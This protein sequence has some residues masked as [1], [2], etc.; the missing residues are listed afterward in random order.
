VSRRRP[1]WSSLGIDP[2]G[3][4]REIKRAYAKK[5]KEIDVEAEPAKFI[6][7]RKQFEQAQSQARWIGADADD[8]DDDD[9][10]AD[11]ADDGDEAVHAAAGAAL[12]SGALMD[13]DEWALGDVGG[14]AFFAPV[15]PP[16]VRATPWGQGRDRVAAHFADIEAALRSADAGREG[17]IDRA[18]RALWANPRSRRSMPPRMWSTGWRIWR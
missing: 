5:L 6:A 16:P 10:D 15:V 1:P 18:V 8:D 12:A 3:D 4:E 9:G 13:A 11:W 17:A 7:L 14:A 2:T